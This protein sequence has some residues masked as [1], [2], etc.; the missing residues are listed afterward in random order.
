MNTR[1]GRSVLQDLADLSG[2]EVSDIRMDGL[3]S[4]YAGAV[5]EQKRRDAANAKD[6][7]LNLPHMVQVQNKIAERLEAEAS[8]VNGKL[9]VASLYEAYRLVHAHADRETDPGL[10]ALHGHLERMWK[11]S[12]TASI[13]ANLYLTLHDHYSRNF[14][15]SAAAQVLVEIGQNGYTTLPLSDLTHIASTIE[16]Q[17]DFDRAVVYHGLGGQLP[18]QVKARRFILALLNSDDEDSNYN[19][20]GMECAPPFLGEEG[21]EQVDSFVPPRSAPTDKV[22]TRG[23]K[24]QK[25]AQQF[26]SDS[27]EEL[28]DYLSRDLYIKEAETDTYLNDDAPDDIVHVGIIWTQS[29]YAGVE[30]MVYVSDQHPDTALQAADE[31][32]E[33]YQRN[34]TETMQ[35]WENDAREDLRRD[36]SLEEGEPSDEEVWELADTYMREQSHGRV[37]TVTSGELLS[38]LR[39]LAP[40]KEGAHLILVAL[41]EVA[42]QA[43]GREGPLTSKKVSGWKKALREGMP[44]RTADWQ[45]AEEVIQSLG[46]H[47]GNHATDVAQS[48]RNVRRV[49]AVVREEDIIANLGDVNYIDYGGLLVVNTE[50]GPQG[51]YIEAPES[52][53]GQWEIFRFDLDKPSEDEWFMDDLESVGSFIGS[54][55]DELREAFM[56]EDVK[57]RA[58]AYES[59]GSYHGFNNLD[60]YP[61]TLDYR[62]VYEFFG[63]P[64]DEEVD[65]E[66]YD[67]E[68]AWKKALREGM[69]GRTADWQQAEEVIQSLGEHAGNYATDVAQSARNVQEAAVDLR[70]EFSYLGYE[71]MTD[72]DWEDVAEYFMSMGPGDR[73]PEEEDYVISSSGNLGTQT[74]VSQV[75]G[76]Y[77]GTFRSD[78]EALDAIR[79][80]GNSGNFRPNV[81]YLSDHGNYQLMEDFDWTTP[82]SQPSGGE[83][84]L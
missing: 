70:D 59:V 73:T 43:R 18:H 72:E 55:A 51:V 56:S 81:W 82:S 52:D 62:E 74:E 1:H 16:S 14:P 11:R 61:L 30:G 40:E 32:W 48:A 76:S 34:D 37:W 7:R 64:I 47:A 68:A 35:M 26:S 8:E 24:A 29:G 19:L 79:E 15:K 69:P 22:K 5:D 57:E 80:K 67:R 66:F 12:R 60:G 38:M 13:T 65:E 9:P 75:G 25:S 10:R 2:H 17:D 27:V 45:Q 54:S 77:L 3:A 36:R 33:E 71:G 49:K 6:F 44:G 41:G 21:D 23:P 28:Q 58:W 84:D 83:W 4:R 63:E 31:M 39:E 78:D 46:E 20:E 42:G 50:Y 53:E